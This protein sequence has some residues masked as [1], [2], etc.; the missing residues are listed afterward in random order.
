VDTCIS[1][2]D[3]G[4]LVGLL[5]IDLRKAFDM[6]NINIL[7]NKLQLYGCSK[8]TVNW[9]SSYLNGRSKKIC[10]N[11][12]YSEAELIMNGVPQGS[13][14]GPLMFIL[15]I[16]DLPC[17]IKD[18]DTEMYADDTS[19]TCI[20][21]SISE[22]QVKLSDTVNVISNWCKENRLIINVSKSYYMVLCSRQKRIH[23]ESSVLNISLYGKEIM[24]KDCIKVLGLYIDHH[25]TWKNHIEQLC[26]KLSKLIGLLYRIRFYL[27]RD[28]NVLFY[29]SYVL[30]HLDYAINVWGG[31]SNCYIDKVQ[32]LQ[33]R[34]ART[35]LN[36]NYGSSSQLNL[37]ELQWMTV[38]QRYDYQVFLLLFK[39][40][41]GLVP[42][43]L[44]YFKL[45]HNVYNFRS[46]TSSLLHVPHPHMNLMKTSFQYRGALLW[47]SLPSSIRSIDK[48][49]V[50]KTALKAYF[51]QVKI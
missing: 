43:T 7:L 5:A 4:D 17:H 25:L 19:V 45:N 30:P 6:L 3:G 48:L 2:I 23:L 29:N 10:V 44:N 47:N 50:F 11:N 39:V 26:V 46:T 20:A 18:C 12:N 35:V 36:V 38:R 32:V 24:Y 51:R 49:A 13:I 40:F 1:A 31:A 34:A 14:L 9:F 28:T 22:L 8:N 16:N 33:N 15:Y 42:A 41:N 21:K 37:K 27:D